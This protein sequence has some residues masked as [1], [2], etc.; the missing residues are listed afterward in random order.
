MN[1]ELKGFLFAMLV[2][3]LIISIVSCNLP[4]KVITIEI[5]S[6]PAI[7]AS[8]PPPSETALP[9]ENEITL[10][11]L[12]IP[13]AGDVL[14]WID[15][16]E[17]VFVPKG[18]FT[19]GQDGDIP[20]DHAPA[21]TVTVGGF[22]IHKAEVTN[23][24]YAAC[25]AA[26]VC[27]PPAQEVGTPY[28]YA[29]SSKWNAPVSGVSWIQASQYCDNI[30][31]RLPTEAEWE[32]AAR[33]SENR[34][35]PWGEDQPTCSL[36]NYDNCLEPS[37][38][39]NVRSYNDGASDYKLMD[40]AGNVSE[41][42]NDW[43]DSEYYTSSPASNPVG[44]VDGTEKVYRGGSYLSSVEDINPVM[45]FSAEP[46]KHAADIGF[47]CV[48]TGD[49][50]NANGQYTGS[51][52]PR[53]CSALPVAV[54]QPETQ[55]TWTPLPCE[56]ATI[57]GECYLNQQGKPIT[58][59]V[60]L[61][62]NCMTNILTDFTSNISENL[63]CTANISGESASYI[64][65][66]KNM[67]Q[68]SEVDI[69]YCHVYA[70][71]EPNLVCPAGYHLD[72]QSSVCVA[73]NTWV[74]SPPCPKD[75]FEFLDQCFSPYHQGNFY[76]CPAGYKQTTLW[77]DDYCVPFDNCIVNNAN[78]IC[79]PPVCPG[80]AQFDP[81]NNCCAQ[82][83]NNLPVCPAGLALFTDPNNN[84]SHC[85]TPATITL[86]CELRY[87]TMPYCPTP[88][89]TPTKEP[90]CHEEC[91]PAGVCSTVCD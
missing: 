44:P 49:N 73:D 29:Q 56:S 23:Q 90:N 69:S 1:K 88:T 3:M 57:Y 10:E 42:V 41:W 89:S 7:I 87:V 75:N 21:H 79:E 47:R 9:E 32:Y 39:G 6:T 77:G 13:V 85:K 48:L 45:R 91:D 61:Q 27:T 19:M 25:V 54:N 43:Y 50:V 74:P 76:G 38:P 59:I 62:K 60:I 26:G 34:T 67:F 14:T 17:F 15:L 5:S 53:S 66:G 4:V 24:Q 84:I 68:G 63:Q 16:S 18:E 28:W 86:A 72:A 81:V 37:E 35:Y 58:D 11:D 36:L 12:I 20:T 52:V 40:M 80:N 2:I 31:S 83:I 71:K 70:V 55:P 8:S 46:E 65:D 30:N 22:W 64:C 82:P 51:Y 33:G 78:Q